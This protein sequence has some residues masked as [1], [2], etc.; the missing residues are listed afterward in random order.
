MHCA[1]AYQMDLRKE[2]LRSIPQLAIKSWRRVTLQ[3]S[4]SEVAEGWEHTSCNLLRSK[5]D[6]V[7]LYECPHATDL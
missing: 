4:V 7:D 3:V 5:S 2:L 1:L 6:L